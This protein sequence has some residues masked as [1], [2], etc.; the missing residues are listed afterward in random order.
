MDEH[1][2]DSGRTPVRGLWI[3]RGTSIHPLP[4]SLI[5]HIYHG[6]GHSFLYNKAR[7][8]RKLRSPLTFLENKLPGD[9][10]IR[11]HRNYI[12]NIDCIETCLYHEQVIIMQHGL[13][14]PVSRR[15]R[16]QLRLLLERGGQS[17]Q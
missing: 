7:L 6:R 14:I 1:V 12:V 5:S 17:I 13:V 11:T 9:Q 3:K 2:I 4:F 16:R 15:K 8:L 10:F